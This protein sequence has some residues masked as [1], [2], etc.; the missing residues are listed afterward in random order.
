MTTARSLAARAIPRGLLLALAFTVV[1]VPGLA[2]AGGAVPAP[3]AAAVTFG[4]DPAADPDVVVAGAALER[5]TWNADGPAFPGDLP[6]SLTADYTSDLPAGWIGWPLAEPLDQD[7]P[8]T[9]AAV[10]VIEPEGFAADPYGYF[11]ISWGLWNRETCGLERTGSPASAAGDTFQLAEFDWFPN[12]SPWFGGPWLSPSLFGAADPENPLFE[13]YGA[14][15]N[16]TFGSVE[17][18]LPLGVPLLAVMEH[19]P[20]DGVMVV[21]VYELG[22]GAP[23]PVPGAVTVVPLGWL[24][25]PEYVLDTIG[26]TL[27]H[28]GW[29]WGETP[30]LVARV[31]FHLL[32]VHRG[33]LAV[34]D[35]PSLLARPRGE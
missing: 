32:A 21:Q 34:R 30:A 18:R 14:F 23:V 7:V 19:R 20:A 13:Q 33:T 25:R 17:A 26:L 16:M 15:A 28:D 12:V 29:Q 6:G 31:T 9:A 5:V 10:F 3:P 11:E 4:T 8:F 2:R 27:W 22:E 1:L 24:S 35:L